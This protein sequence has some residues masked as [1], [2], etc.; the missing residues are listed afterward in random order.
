MDYKKFLHDALN[1]GPDWAVI[2]GSV[3]TDKEI[4][5]I[6][7]EYIGDALP[8][9]PQCG[10]AC[11]GI[12]DR[13]L[14]QYRHMDLFQN[15]TYIH[16]RVPRVTC[17]NGHISHVPV[18]WAA[19][20]SRFT[21]LYEAMI[22]FLCA[23]CPV[24]VVAKRARVD[25]KAIWRIIERYVDQYIKK[26]D[27]SNVRRIGVDETSRRKNHKYISVFMDMD[28]RQVIGVFDGKGKDVIYK[29]KKHFL[30][31][32]GKIENIIDISCDM[33]KAFLS[34]MKEVFPMARITIDRFHI[35]KM[36][37]EVVNSVRKRERSEQPLLNGAMYA[38]LKNPSN[39]KP[40]EREML[41][42]INKLNIQTAKTYKFRVLF[43]DFFMQKDIHAAKGFLKAWV[44]S[45]LMS[46]V[47]ELKEVSE[48]IR[49]HWN[50][51]VNWHLSKINNG[52][53]EGFNGILQALKAGARGYR[54]ISYIIQI[55]YL[56][57]TKSMRPNP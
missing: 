26:L 49:R 16:A 32:G 20:G 9:C 1:F 13:R 37:N 7:L 30:E 31:R 25:D 53:L 40:H 28:T 11:T 19:K 34:G 51:I 5:V 35:V 10:C 42:E 8:P 43:N 15:I 47:K 38:L 14:H 23:S 2:N 36:L 50:L 45:A 54:T 39:L 57:G 12:H 33:S 27:L 4:S 24:N 44:S 17:E 29:F 41:S 48:T 52:I 55:A 3:D 56:I 46:G 22:L 6:E 18:S 21:L